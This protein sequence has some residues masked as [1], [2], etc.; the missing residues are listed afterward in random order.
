MG[1]KQDRIGRGHELLAAVCF[2][3]CWS[4]MF[5][6][7]ARIRLGTPEE[8]AQG[9]DVVVETTDLG[10]FP[11]QVKS[12]RKYLKRHFK[13]YPDVP[14]LVIYPTHTEEEVRKELARLIKKERRK[15]DP[16]Y[17]LNVEWIQERPPEAK[18]EELRASLGD[19]VRRRP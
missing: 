14:V 7:V 2:D 8:D 11:V 6:W 17:P 13:K 15:R 4:R 3:Q 1:E 9:K 5:P 12:S 16:S 10:D 18:T 19:L